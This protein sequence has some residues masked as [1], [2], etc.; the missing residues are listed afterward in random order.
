MPWNG[1][2]DAEVSSA[3]SAKNIGILATT[4]N[5]RNG[6]VEATWLGTTRGNNLKPWSSSATLGRLKVFDK[7]AGSGGGKSTCQI[8][9]EIKTIH[10]ATISA[11]A[12]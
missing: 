1:A 5:G 8:S 12:K 7:Q 9:G 6:G 4:K 2:P 11:L 3:S 10:R